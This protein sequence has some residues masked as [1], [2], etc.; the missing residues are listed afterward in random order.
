MPTIE[1][2]LTPEELIYLGINNPDNASPQIRSLLGL[3]VDDE[4]EQ[5]K[6]DRKERVPPTDCRVGR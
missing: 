5:A 2:G 3:L 1:L 6:E 4:P